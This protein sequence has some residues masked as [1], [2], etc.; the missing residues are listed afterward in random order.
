[1]IGLDGN[2]SNK[3]GIGMSSNYAQLTKEAWDTFSNLKKTYEL[4]MSQRKY[5]TNI[6]NNLKYKMNNHNFKKKNN[7]MDSS[8][9]LT[10]LIYDSANDPREKKFLTG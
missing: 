4:K 5:K 8:S 1:M 10:S 2:Q 3:T 9:T 7:L 6:S